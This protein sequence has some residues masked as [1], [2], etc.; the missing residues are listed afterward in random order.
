[1]AQQQ[2]TPKLYA[3]FRSRCLGDSVLD[4]YFSFF[5]NILIEESI[6]VVNANDL[7]K[8]FEE[9]YQFPIP[10][11]FVRQVLPNFRKNITMFQK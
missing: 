5:A 1:M 6:S 4:V 10:L 9:R 2:E 3:A 11:T 8:K 7:L